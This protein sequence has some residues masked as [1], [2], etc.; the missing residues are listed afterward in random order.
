MGDTMTQPPSV[1]ARYPRNGKTAREMAE[2]A[3]KSIRTVKRWTSEPREVYLERAEQRQDR[4]RELRATG[5]SI[6]AIAAELGCSVGTVHRALKELP[7][8]CP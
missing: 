7:T 2:W 1:Y 8:G 5:M 4:I 6:R 3:G